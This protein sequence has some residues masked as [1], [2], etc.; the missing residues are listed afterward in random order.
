MVLLRLM[1]TY[2]QCGIGACLSNARQLRSVH[3]NYTL[4]SHADNLSVLSQ[5]EALNL[6]RQCPST[7]VQFGCNAQ[8]W[9]VPFIIYFSLDMIADAEPQVNRV[10]N[11]DPGGHVDMSTY[12]VSHKSPDIPEQFLVVY[13]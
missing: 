7:L 1:L 13:A 3:I 5:D 11:R 2:I 10:A 8:V 12:L 4:H 6:V 9:Q